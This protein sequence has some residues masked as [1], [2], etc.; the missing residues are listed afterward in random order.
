MKRSFLKRTKGLARKAMSPRQTPLK[1]STK[2]MRLRAPVSPEERALKEAAEEVVAERSDGQCEA[3]VEKHP[4]DDW[5]H[6]VRKGQGGPWSGSNGLW[7]CRR[8]HDWIGDYPIGA[9]AKGWGLWRNDNPAMERVLYRG[10]WVLLG[11]DGSVTP[12]SAP[13]TEV[14]S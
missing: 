4:G 10:E 11:D 6:R 7:L 12:T 14:A 2:R 9:R 1:R 13:E 8:V 5:H 3:C